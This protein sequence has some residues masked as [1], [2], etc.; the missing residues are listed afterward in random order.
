MKLDPKAEKWIDSLAGE[1][2]DFDWDEHNRTKN[3]KHK[4]E[5]GDIEAMFENAVIFVGRI[6][7][8]KHHEPRWLLLGTSARGRRLALIFTRT[9]ERLRPISCRSMRDNERQVFREAL[10]IEED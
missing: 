6:V 9:G 3:R 7:E 1:P 4:V 5:A 8:P 10:G 2:G